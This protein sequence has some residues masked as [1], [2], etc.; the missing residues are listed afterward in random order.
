[1]VRA[2]HEADATPLAQTG[3][4]AIRVLCDVLAARTSANEPF[5]LDKY[6]PTG[7]KAAGNSKHKLYFLLVHLPL[8]PPASQRRGPAVV[9]VEL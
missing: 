3:A 9:E 2:C 7:A 5:S 8:L 4:K 1:M 6:S